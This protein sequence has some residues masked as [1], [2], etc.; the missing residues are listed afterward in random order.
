MVSQVFVLSQIGIGPLLIRLIFVEA[1]YPGGEDSSR[2]ASILTFT[3]VNQIV[4]GLVH[5]GWVLEV[6]RGH[7]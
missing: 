5:R 3:R 7:D 1:G 4:V 6:E 2:D